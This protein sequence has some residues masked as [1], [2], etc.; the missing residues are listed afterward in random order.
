MQLRA[1]Q[2]KQS[3]AAKFLN[4]LHGPKAT[5]WEERDLHGTLDNRG[6]LI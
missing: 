4:G 3:K 5:P 6:S 1:A 2:S